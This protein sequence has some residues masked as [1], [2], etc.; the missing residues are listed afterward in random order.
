M[1]GI[2]TAMLENVFNCVCKYN[3]NVY[4]LWLNNWSGNQTEWVHHAFHGLVNQPVKFQMLKFFLKQNNRRYKQWYMLK[5][6]WYCV[7]CYFSTILQGSSC[8]CIK[9]LCCCT[10]P[11]REIKLKCTLQTHQVYKYGTRSYV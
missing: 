2:F 8:C 4:L 9:K 5:H 3:H 7:C 10:K 11:A 6:L 1:H